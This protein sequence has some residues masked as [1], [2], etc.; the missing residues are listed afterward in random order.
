MSTITGGNES[1]GTANGIRRF[2]DA[3]VYIHGLLATSILLLW[4]TGLPITFHDPFAWLMAL[5][6]YDNVVLLHVIAGAVLMATSAFYVVYGLL[7]MIGGVTTL[8]NVVPGRGDI[9]EALD[10]LQ[11]LAGFRGQ[12]ESGK[13][14]FLQ[15]AEMWII[16]AETA[17]M[18]GTGIVLWSGTTSG[19]S[20]APAYLIVRDVHAIVAVTMLVGVTFHLFMTHAKEFP[21]DRSMFTGRVSLGRACEEWE[22][23]ARSEIGR[24]DATCEELSHTTILT[25]SVIVG[26]I[27]FAVV[28]TGVILQYVL[29]P[30]PTGGLSVASGVAPNTLP[31]GLLG[32]VYAAG[33]NLAMLVIIGAIGALAYGF[34]DRWTVG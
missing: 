11:Y 5:L 15:K 31:G 12:P 13:Y 21:L 20:P 32:M 3:Q 24:A 23:W 28:W 30:I 33:L 4:V 9:R 1:V 27:L 8:S 19:A 34:V 7:G 17:V 25:T 18:I 10:H 16:A 26:M 14:T 29:S 6:G 22:G 2:T